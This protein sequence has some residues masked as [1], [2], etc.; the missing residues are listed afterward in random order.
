[1]KKMELQMQK[2]LNVRNNL[3]IL[4]ILPVFF[5][6]CN[7]NDIQSN[8]ISIVN[9][10]IHDLMINSRDS[11]FYMTKENSNKL[12]LKRFNTYH[13]KHDIKSDSLINIVFSKDEYENIQQQSLNSNY[14]SD[15]IIN[16]ENVLF[17]SDEKK[18]NVIFNHVSKPIYT[19]DNEYALIY[20]LSIGKKGVYFMPFIYVYKKYGD[21]WKKVHKI[22]YRKF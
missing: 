12:I 20:N 17:I 10:F 8:D 11:I 3:F 6:S 14:W 18:S 22:P 21:S 16:I 2:V 9:A 7:K 13:K 1:M 15:D 19:R 5:Y 4:L